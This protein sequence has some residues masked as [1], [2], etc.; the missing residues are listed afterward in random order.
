MQGGVSGGRGWGTAEVRPAMPSPEGPEERADGRPDAGGFYQ[1]SG[2]FLPK[3]EESG[4]E[5]Q[6]KSPR[7]IPARSEPVDTRIRH[8][9]FPVQ[10]STVAKQGKSC[11]CCRN[12]H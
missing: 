1:T 9:L 2:R 11:Y 6:G 3:P 4:R 12:H 7:R 10:G 5:A 8:G